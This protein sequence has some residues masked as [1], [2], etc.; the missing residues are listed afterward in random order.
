VTN[1]SAQAPFLPR[2]PESLEQLDLL[3]LTVAK[4]RKVH[5]D[6]I[7]YK[8]LRYL[9]PVPAAYVGEAVTIRCDPRDLAEIRVFHHDRFLCRAICPELAGRTI[10]IK[11]ITA[12]RNTRRRRPASSSPS[13]T[14]GSSSS[15][16]PSAATATSGSATAPRR[17]QDTLQLQ[18]LGHRRPRVDAYEAN[19]R[20]N[21]RYF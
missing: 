2:L 3:P 12:A 1:E 10:G 11:D 15:A 20:T 7:H 16:T 13:S 6:G 18:R 17:R 8:S 19:V 4:P 5:P 9:D 21:I 14:A